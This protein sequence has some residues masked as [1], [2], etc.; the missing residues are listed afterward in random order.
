MRRE[1]KILENIFAKSLYNFR[2]TCQYQRKTSVDIRKI[3]NCEV[4]SFDFTDRRAS[5][6]GAELRTTAYYHLAAKSF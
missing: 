2:R 4:D 5:V 6:S 3:G 1:Y